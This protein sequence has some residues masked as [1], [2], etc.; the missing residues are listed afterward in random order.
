MQFDQQALCDLHAYV[1]RTHPHTC[2]FFSV[3]NGANTFIFDISACFFL[4]IGMSGF[5]IS[6]Q[7][8]HV[9][10]LFSA[11]RSCEI[12][13]CACIVLLNTYITSS[14]RTS[15]LFTKSTGPPNF[16]VGVI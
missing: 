6:C 1:L 2:T 7:I 10:M 16:E 9:S 13:L 11:H 14:E 5:V 4:F 8:R 3:E 12:A 15:I